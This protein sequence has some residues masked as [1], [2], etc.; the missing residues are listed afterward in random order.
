MESGCG[1]E[2]GWVKINR[3][4]CVVFYA[5]RC[6]SLAVSGHWMLAGEWSKT[7]VVRATGVRRVLCRDGVGKKRKPSSPLGVN[8]ASTPQQAR[9]AV[10]WRVFSS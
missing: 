3:T 9:V 7:M 5:S 10:D 2:G 6:C 1:G 8:S 4:A